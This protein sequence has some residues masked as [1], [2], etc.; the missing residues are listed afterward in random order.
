MMKCDHWIYHDPVFECEKYN[1]EMLIYSPWAGHRTFAYDYMCFARPAVVVELGSYYGCSAFAF[2]QAIKDHALDTAF[3]AVDTWQGDDFTKNDYTEDIYGAYKQIND[4]CFP[5][6]HSHMLRMTFDEACGGFADKSIDLL[7]IDGSHKYEDVK[8]D[9]LRWRT[10]VADDGVIFFHDVGMDLL[11]GEP[12]GSHIFWE[13]LKRE[14][15]FTVEFPFSNGLG[16]LF[17]SAERY[18]QFR[19]LVSMEHYQ[20]HINLQDTVN[21]DM[22]RKNAFTIRDLRVYN[23]DLQ[24]QIRIKDQH[25]SQYRMDTA[26]AAEYIATLERRCAEFEQ[27]AAQKDACIC[28]LQQSCAE[29]E[30]AANK[31]K[32]Y[33]CGLEEQLEQ[34]RSFASDKERYAEELQGQVVQLNAFA[35]DKDRYAAELQ[36]QMEQLSSFASVKERYAEELEKQM[37]QLRSF[38]SAKERYVEELETQMAQ[39]RTFASAKE[40]YAGELE[41]QM[42]QLQIFAASKDSYAAEL[43]TQLEQLR[44]FASSKEHY[45]DEL[46]TQITE[47]NRYADGKAEA[48]ARLEKDLDCLGQFVK[49]KEDYIAELEKQ[50]SDLNIYADSKCIYI[51]QL[52]REKLSVRAEAAGLIE[53]LAQR[54]AQIQAITDRYHVQKEKMEALCDKVRKLPFSKKLVEEMIASMEEEQKTYGTEI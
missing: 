15:P 3:Y 10:K 51:E 27:A 31:R 4:C 50:V 14:H 44:A 9:Y 54:D 21:K 7:H 18:R 6:V 19:E 46:Q 41:T 24:E 11:F 43:E 13:E 1:P 33:I 52:E 22:I 2:L 47:L 36:H 48:A 23:A 17:Y 40:G 39:L 20:Q 45:V 30:T 28:S 32:E 38:A 16:I 37:T 35:S 25:L 29:Q 53:Q 5:G 34:L 12:M 26:A 42:E 8:N 49:Q